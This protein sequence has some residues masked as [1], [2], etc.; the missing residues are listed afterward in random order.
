MHKSLVALST[1]AALGLFACQPQTQSTTKNEE[2]AS[3]S[4]DQM[5]E[6]QKHAY[7]MGASMGKFVSARAEQSEQLGLSLDQAVLRQGFQDGLNGT[8]AFS[9]E[10]VQQLAQAGEQV[11]RTKQQEQASKMA[12]E[13]KAKGEA[14]LA[15]NA[16]RDGVITTESGLQYEVLTAGEGES[17]TAEDIVKVHYRGTLIDGT[18][19]DS[20]YSRGEPIEFAL[21]R[22]IP[23]WT[24]GVQLMNKGAKYR[25]HIPADI[26][27]GSRNQ[28]PIPANSTLVF[29]VELLDFTSTKID[30]ET[31]S[32]Q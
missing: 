16:Q 22:V 32:E 6:E 24:E 17:P 29:E 19:F 23:G 8:L 5:T 4:A 30:A 9:E 18:E 13:N 12:E 31:T 14:Y 26:A 27:Y 11:I 28:G 21:N 20:S 7:A 25:F 15:E 10:E 3:V 1:V 2:V